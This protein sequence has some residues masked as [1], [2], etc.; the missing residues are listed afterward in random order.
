MENIQGRGHFYDL[1]VDGGIVSQ[2][3]RFRSVNGLGP[4]SGSCVN[5]NTVSGLITAGKFLEKFR[6]YVNSK[7]H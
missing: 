1:E 2:M 6:V 7:S 5:G 3:N 4:T